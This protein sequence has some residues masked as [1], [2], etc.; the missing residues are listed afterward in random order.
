MPLTMRPYSTQL[1][2]LTRLLLLCWSRRRALLPQELPSALKL[3]T[4]SYPSRRT[5]TMA[6][7]GSKAG[8]LVDVVSFNHAAPVDRSLR[9]S[10]VGALTAC[11]A[12]TGPLHVAATRVVFVAWSP[13]TD[14]M[15]VRGPQCRN[16]YGIPSS[17]SGCGARYPC[18][19]GCP[20]QL[21]ANR[22]HH[23]MSR[24]VAT[25]V[26][27][28]GA[29][30]ED[31]LLVLPNVLFADRVFN[32]GRPIHGP[33]FTLLLKWWS[34][35]AHAL[36]ATLPTPIDVELWGVPA[37]AWE[38]TTAQ[39]LLNGWCWVRSR[40]PDT[41][42]RHDLSFRLSAWCMRQELIPTAIDLL[43]AEP[44]DAEIEAPPL[45]RGLVYPID[46]TVVR[47][48][49]MMEDRPPQPP[50]PGGGHG[51]HRHRRRRG[52]WS[53]G[54]L[55]AGP[56]RPCLGLR[57]IQDSVLQREQQ[58]R[59][60]DGLPVEES[61]LLD[62]TL[63]Q[64]GPP[65][66]DDLPVGAHRPTILGLLAQAASPVQSMAEAHIASQA[67]CSS[68]SSAL[69]VRPEQAATAH[70]AAN[71][72][73]PVDSPALGVALVEGLAD[74]DCSRPEL[75]T[76]A[77]ATAAEPAPPPISAPSLSSPCR[78]PAQASENVIVYTRRSASG[79]AK[80]PA[81]VAFLNK[82][83]K[84]LQNLAP[85]EGIQKQRKKTLPSG[86]MPRR[87]RRVAN[88]PPEQVS[89]AS[90]VCRKLGFAEEDGKISSKALERY[91]HVFSKPL[92]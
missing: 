27:D 61:R 73:L 4:A 41:L 65:V 50:P 80:T 33:G 87:S 9:I 43:I 36:G 49:P 71:S 10:G 77:L 64:D 76:L 47:S 13:V 74:G 79:T 14:C 90:S 44:T 92:S 28:A 81:T 60:H 48:L 5:A 12:P 69:V 16:C 32:G 6:S 86:F 31:Y 19:S 11:L 25:P 55:A 29:A 72:S 45:K 37:H 17:L 82:I 30:P 21:E 70:L 88:L 2:Q 15:G 38:L 78:T 52:S 68:G 51:R 39:Q 75:R 40:H 22:L 24:H 3:A 84:P 20:R 83:T 57:R 59:A 66:E 91:A 26:V 89:A 42:A 54:S 8:A 18:P 1:A 46:A 62:E 85:V 53:P 63:D 23:E 34:R 67:A 56:N 58:V 7:S 35:L